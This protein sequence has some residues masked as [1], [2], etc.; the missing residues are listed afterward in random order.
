MPI[1][2]SLILGADVGGEARAH[3][4]ASVPEASTSAR[5]ISTSV[6]LAA[7]RLFD[8]K[9]GQVLVDHIVEIEG[10]RIRAVGP[11]KGGRADGE[12]IDFGDATLLPG[13]IDIH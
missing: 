10:G 2:L 4:M 12:V 6:R 7:D 1:N 8:T 13:L 5:P 11:R 9:S 3:E